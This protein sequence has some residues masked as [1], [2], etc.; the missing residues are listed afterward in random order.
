VRFAM[1]AHQDWEQHGSH[2]SRAALRSSI[3]AGKGSPS[4]GHPTRATLA[5][6]KKHPT[7]CQSL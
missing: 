3:T 4:Q 1:G 5:T 6:R 7:I 2:L